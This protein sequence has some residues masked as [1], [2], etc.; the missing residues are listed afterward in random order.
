MLDPK[1]KNL[2]I[3]VAVA[4]AVLGT[5]VAASAAFDFLN[6]RVAIVNTNAEK[7]TGGQITADAFIPQR[8]QADFAFGYG[9]ITGDRVLLYPLHM[10]GF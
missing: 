8:G 9:I 2:M 4:A 7:V 1:Q 6:I 10:R 3:L 5:P